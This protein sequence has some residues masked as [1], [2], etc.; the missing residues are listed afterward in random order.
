MSLRV[1]GMAG[2]G[3]GD[4]RRGAVRSRRPAVELVLLRSAFERIPYLTN[5][6]A[7]CTPN[8]AGYQHV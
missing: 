8:T 4:A 7:E 2:L 6:R 1:K 3:D 5:W